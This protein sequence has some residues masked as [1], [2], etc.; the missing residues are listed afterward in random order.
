[1]NNDKCETC[2]FFI[3]YYGLIRGKIKKIEKGHCGERVNLKKIKSCTVYLE[4]PQ[5]DTNKDI[6]VYNHLTDVKNRLSAISKTLSQIT[7][8]FKN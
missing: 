3:Q 6:V 8:A 2:E 5:Q 7:D 4:K 1:M